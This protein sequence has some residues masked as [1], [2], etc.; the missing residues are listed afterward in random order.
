MG[1]TVFK[2]AMVLVWIAL[3]HA[4][5]RFAPLM[6]RPTEGGKDAG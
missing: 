3:I 6:W 5:D 4:I 1:E 2:L